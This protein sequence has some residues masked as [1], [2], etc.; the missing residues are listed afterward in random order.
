MHDVFT[1][2]ALNEEAAVAMEARRRIAAEKLIQAILNDR[3]MTI[4]QLEKL[5]TPFFHHVRRKLA[6]EMKR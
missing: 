6:L 2:R 5:A 1:L 3:D 4:E